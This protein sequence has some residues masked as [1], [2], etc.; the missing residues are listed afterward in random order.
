[1][2][3]PPVAYW[4]R[5]LPTEQKGSDSNPVLGKWVLGFEPKD[6][7]VIRNPLLVAKAYGR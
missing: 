5:H 1:M 3:D 2:D 4:S 7:H 6:S